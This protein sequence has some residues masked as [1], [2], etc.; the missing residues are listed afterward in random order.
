MCVDSLVDCMQS[1]SAEVVAINNCKSHEF[2]ECGRWASS[3]PS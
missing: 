2:P 3:D 1:R